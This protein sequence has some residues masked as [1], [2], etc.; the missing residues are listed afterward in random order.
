[1]LNEV[2]FPMVIAPLISRVPHEALITAPEPPSTTEVAPA[3]VKVPEPAFVKVLATP[4]LPMVS[5]PLSVLFE[6]QTAKVPPTL[7]VPVPMK[8]LRLEISPADPVESVAPL[9]R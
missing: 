5:V 4:V 7:L 3:R 8:K 2:K 9:S 6:P 1:M